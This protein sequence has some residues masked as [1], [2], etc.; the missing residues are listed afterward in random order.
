MNVFAEL[1]TRV[2]NDVLAHDDPVEVVERKA[3]GKFNLNLRSVI[4]LSRNN[5]F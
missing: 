2:P 3:R 4:I 1:A 5:I